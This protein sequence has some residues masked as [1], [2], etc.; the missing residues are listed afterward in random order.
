[1]CFTGK[2]LVHANA[3]A[4]ALRVRALRNLRSLCFCQPSHPGGIAGLP[5]VGR[6]VHASA[7]SHFVSHT[8]STSPL[9]LKA[10]A[11]TVHWGYF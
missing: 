1:M 9:S 11:S 7:C 2:A 8:H 6:S 10:D 5:G 4:G 3:L